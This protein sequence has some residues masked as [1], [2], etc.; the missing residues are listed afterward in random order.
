MINLLCIRV[1]VMFVMLLTSCFLVLIMVMVW[2]TH[3]LLV[4]SFAATIGAVELLYLSAVLYKFDQGGYASLALAL[5]LTAIM[6][7]WNDVQGRKYYYELDHMI[8]RENVA[9]IVKSSNPC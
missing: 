7:V 1:A 9:K 8:S 6:F 3:L 2:K 5:A 4:I